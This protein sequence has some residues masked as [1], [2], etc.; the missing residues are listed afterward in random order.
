MYLIGFGTR[1]QLL[2]TFNVKKG[3]AKMD[4]KY[5]N[6]ALTY[7]TPEAQAIINNKVECDNEMPSNEQYVDINLKFS[8]AMVPVLKFM[9]KTMLSI[10]Y[11]NDDD[12]NDAAKSKIAGKKTSKKSGK[13]DDIFFN[14]KLK[15]LVMEMYACVLEGEATDDKVRELLIEYHNVL[16]IIHEKL[17]NMV[18]KCIDYT[19]VGDDDFVDSDFDTIDNNAQPNVVDF[20]NDEYDD[21]DDDDD[22]DDSDSNNNY[23]YIFKKSYKL[24]IAKQ[25][26]IC[27]T[28]LDLIS[29]TFAGNDELEFVAN[30]MSIIKK[31]LSILHIPGVPCFLKLFESKFTQQDIEITKWYVCNVYFKK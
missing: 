24:L 12:I 31:E 1:S 19:S 25:K 9:Q 20:E 16:D 22:D 21:D 15:K 4:S 13:Y 14:K 23:G 29:V 3:V 6:I 5:Q 11:N 8:K 10:C 2:T 17:H 27:D 18:I 30:H 26:M 7:T 28:I